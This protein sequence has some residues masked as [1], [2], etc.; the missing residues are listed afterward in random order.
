MIGNII[1][2]IVSKS[3]FSNSTIFFPKS[4]AKENL[5]IPYKSILHPKNANG[6]SVIIL[7]TDRFNKNGANLWDPLRSPFGSLHWNTQSVGTALA[8]SHSG[9]FQF[10]SGAKENRR[11]HRLRHCTNL[12]KRNKIPDSV[13]P[14]PKARRRDV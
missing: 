7:G 9:P 3:D 12:F 1:Y 4:S 6:S 8:P 11:T 2:N 14:A 13:S 10:E 5:I